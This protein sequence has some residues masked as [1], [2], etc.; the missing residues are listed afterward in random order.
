[1]VAASLQLLRL[2]ALL[3]LLSCGVL[4]IV[5]ALPP[6]V[7]PPAYPVRKKHKVKPMQELNK[8]GK[9]VSYIEV[10]DG[11]IGFFEFYTKYMRQN[12][13]V[14]FKGALFDQ[15]HASVTGGEK[16]LWGGLSRWNDEFFLKDSFAANLPVTTE[17]NKTEDRDGPREQHSLSD[18]VR[19]MDEHPE[20]LY[21]IAGLER[22]IVTDLPHRFNFVLGQK[23]KA[24]RALAA[25]LEKEEEAA[26]K[27]SG[28]GPSGEAPPKSETVSTRTVELE[29]MYEQI[30]WNQDG[31]TR[32]HPTGGVT[33]DDKAKA[34][35][36][37]GKVLDT[38]IAFD[39]T[40]NN[41][42]L[43]DIP[44][45]YMLQ[46][47]EMLYQ[48]LTMWYS[49][50][51]TSSVLHQDDADNLLMQLEGSKKVML[52]DQE[53]GRKG[54]YGFS[55]LMDSSGADA[56]KRRQMDRGKD[57][58][59]DLSRHSEYNFHPHHPGT[60]PVHQLAV[61][62]DKFPN[63]A[64]TP[65]LLGELEKG[66]MLYIPNKFWHQVNSYSS[67]SGSGSDSS[68]SEKKQRNLAL[69][70]WWGQIDDYGWLSQIFA[71]QD[72]FGAADAWYWAHVEE[73][74]DASNNQNRIDDPKSQTIQ[75]QKTEEEI[76][77]DIERQRRE[78]GRIA[79]RQKMAFLETSIG[80]IRAKKSKEARRCTPLYP[81][82][83][84]G[85]VQ[86]F[87]EDTFRAMVLEMAE[88]ETEA[89][90]RARGKLQEYEKR[91]QEK[92]DK[93]KA[94]D[95][96]KGKGK[97]GGGGDQGSTASSMNKDGAGKGK[98]EL[99]AGKDGKDKK[100]K[101]GRKGKNKGD[102]NEL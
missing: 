2:K 23:E 45:P 34:R 95:K 52:I 56:R 89:S 47:K 67:G 94:G 93:M 60:S 7:S 39:P 84:F 77:T 58:T 55:Y 71:A 11:Q 37:F 96:N 50:G 3:L 90:Y 61:D 24:A 75:K 29:E 72:E 48:S 9:H 100:G 19:R 78:H 73:N 18:F 12:K 38:R 66:D 16:K 92:Q 14:I 85:E 32:E 53:H 88:K 41:T 64:E 26:E 36:T 17:L 69:N 8:K 43:F 91:K 63:F 42:M 62:P 33:D 13:P 54:V 6:G 87:D 99:A 27:E 68:G 1:M 80:K 57:V 25:K 51:G 102:I 5:R 4:P 76:Q 22:Q 31:G 44:I 98:R 46:C 81:D 49:A 83:T 35:A 10:I 40:R 65:K 70:V 28:A 79:A 59:T 86:F 15:K 97:G 20:K 101:K 82:S 74:G 21:T 30:L